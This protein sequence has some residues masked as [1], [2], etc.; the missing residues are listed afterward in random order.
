MF[1]RKRKKHLSPKLNRIIVNSVTRVSDTYDKY[2]DESEVGG[3]SRSFYLFK[4]ERLSVSEIAEKLNVGVGAI[5]QRIRRDYLPPE[6]DLSDI[7]I[8]TRESRIVTFLYNGVEL[9]KKMLSG[10]FSMPVVTISR[11]LKLAGKNPGDEIS[12]VDFTQKG[13]K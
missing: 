8:S 7:S 2:K 12:D 4:G 6:S 10:I 9:N 3:T 11:R 1:I 5:Y 13:K